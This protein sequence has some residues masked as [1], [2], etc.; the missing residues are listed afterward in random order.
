MQVLD[1]STNTYIKTI[2][3][4]RVATAIAIDPA[5]GRG[6]VTGNSCLGAS[7]ASRLPQIL[8][9]S[10]DTVVGTVDAPFGS[11]AVAIG[12]THA[13]VLESGLVDVVDISSGSVLARMPVEIS[14]DRI[15]ATPSFV[16][17]L[18][19][20]SNLVSIISTSTN[21]VVASLLV[22][23]LVDLAA[24]PATNALDV[25][26]EWESAKYSGHSIQTTNI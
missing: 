1:T 23:G 8:D 2:P 13:Y 11:Q 14:S 26:I 19:N 6:Y 24:D 17:V 3:V 22:P 5:T 15:A 20:G 4:N 9:T 7:S 12:G 25:L 18:G 10:S 21:T 16:F